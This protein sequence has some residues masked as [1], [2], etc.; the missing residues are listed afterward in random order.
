MSDF[1]THFITAHRYLKESTYSEEAKAAFYFGVQGPDLFYY[2]SPIRRQGLNYIGVKLHREPANLAI[3]KGYAYVLAH[4]DEVLEAYFSGL[5]LHYLGD[6]HMHPYIG[7]YQIVEQEERTHITREKDVDV[8]MYAREFHQGI[9]KFKPR[10]Y[11]RLSNNIV[12]IITN[13]WLAVCEDEKINQREIKKAC[14]NI[15]FL[16]Q[17]F[18]KSNPI[19]RKLLGLFDR[20][21][22]M[23]GHFKTLEYRGI[24]NL[25]KKPYNHPEGERNYSVPEILDLSL[26]DY[27][28]VISNLYQALNEGKKDYSFPFS[29]S[30]DYGCS[31]KYI[32]NKIKQIEYR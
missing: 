19:L 6:L 11:Y 7:H 8:L 27:Y 15:V 18:A 1:T 25:E 24:L 23:V 32:E 4:R 29:Q 10:A 16:A 13:Y 2:H 5:I 20:K 9:D 30:H 31:A 28:Q 22:T 14:R 12:R 3:D 21:G 26:D 17:V